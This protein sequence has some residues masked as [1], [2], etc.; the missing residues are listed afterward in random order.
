MLDESNYFIIDIETCPIDIEGYKK[1]DEEGKKK[2]I[3]PID[4]R[5]IAIGIRHAGKNTIIQNENEKQLL[6][7]FWTEWMSIKKGR[8]LN[9]VGFNIKDFDLPFAVTRSFVHNVTISPFVVKYVID[10][11]EKVSAYRYGPTRGKLK[12]FGGYMGISDFGM[13]GSDVT[14]LCISQNHEKIKEYLVNDL[15]ITDKM[16]KRLRD[17]K[18]LEIERW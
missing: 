12:E 17:T 11:K 10:L 5:I 9:I 2:L 3:N 7:D 1:L 6:E 16:Y 4:S 15:E 8:S 14:E 18:I 13:D